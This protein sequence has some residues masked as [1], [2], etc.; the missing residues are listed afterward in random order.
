MNAR[1]RH[2]LTLY[3]NA[4]GI[5]DTSTGL[6]LVLF[7][8]FT[9][10]LMGL[11]MIPQPLSFASYIGV[12]VLC[13]GLTYLWTVAKWPLNEYSLPVWLT[14]WKITALFRAMVAMFLV[15]QLA[16]HAIEARWITVALADG[17]FAT[18]QIIGLEQGWM[19]RAV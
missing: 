5:C 6:L 7:P 19:E 16:V 11:A 4:A 18:I 13:V 8:A 17:I 9:F 1:L 3:Q 2:W 10:R 12:F 14:Q 15:W